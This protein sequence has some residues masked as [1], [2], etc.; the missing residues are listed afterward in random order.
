MDCRGAESARVGEEQT[1]SGFPSQ[2]SRRSLIHRALGAAALAGLPTGAVW[3]ERAPTPAQGEGP[4]Y[5]RAKPGDRN[6]DLIHVEGQAAPA[7]G[8][9]LRLSGRV[10]DAGGAPVRGTRVEIW[11]CDHRGV[12]HHPSGA[13]R[14]AADP[15]FQGFG[16]HVT[17][18]DGH[19]AFL[20]LMPVPYPG[21]PPH[22]HVKVVVDGRER[23]TTQLYLKDHPDNDRDFLLGRLGG[24]ARERLLL[25]PRP[26]GEIAG[27]RGFAAGFDFVV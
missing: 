15:G 10:L 24:G 14:G 16:E 2:P 27:A 23:L 25:S 5:P 12:Y 4:F 3:A 20:T 22:I 8:E 26:A 21:R 13:R 11:Q 19:Y 6:N 1:M 9:R 7:Q 18:A 17:D